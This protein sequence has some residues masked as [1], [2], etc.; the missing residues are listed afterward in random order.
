MKILTALL[1]FLAINVSRVNAE[2]LPVAKYLED[3]EHKN[4][5]LGF[6][7]EAVFSGINLV[8]Q[9]IDPPLFCFRESGQESAYA[10]IDKRIKKLQN[11]KKLS[12]D[13]TIDS[14]MMDILIE[15]YPCKQ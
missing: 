2:G 13:M 12:P 14:I 10:I 4:D 9:R 7:L 3:P 8:N 15:E 6:Y 11:E 1:L 5:I